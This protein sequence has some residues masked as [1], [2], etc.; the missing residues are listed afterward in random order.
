MMF[1]FNSGYASPRYSTDSS[2]ISMSFNSA[3]FGSKYFVST[4]IPGPISSTLVADLRLS[5]IFRAMFSS[6]RKCCP[7][8]FLG[9]TGFT[10][11]SYFFGKGINGENRYKTCLKLIV[12]TLMFHI[13][14][15]K[16]KTQNAKRQTPNAKRQTQNSHLIQLIPTQVSIA[17]SGLHHEQT[18][19]VIKHHP[20]V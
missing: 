15:L 6:F 14:N 11:K 13:Y 5:T 8:F 7:S 17:F 4:P 3:H 20:F 1:V 16:R 19:R 10:G 2:S 18:A 12:R 9:L